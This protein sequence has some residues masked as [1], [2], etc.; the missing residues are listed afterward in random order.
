MC[1]TKVT[2]LSEGFALGQES[3]LHYLS[4]VGRMRF[5]PVRYQDNCDAVVMLL[6]CGCSRQL[7]GKERQKLCLPLK[8]F[9]L[10]L[11][12]PNVLIQNIV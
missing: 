4:K 1:W 6:S 3:D 9:C 12:L 11:G 8:Q 10:T 2:S 5:L 7:T